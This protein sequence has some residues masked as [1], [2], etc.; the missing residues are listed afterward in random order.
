[1]QIEN[2]FKASFCVRCAHGT[3]MAAVLRER[4]MELL[5]LASQAFRGIRPRRR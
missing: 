4:C 1:M 3:K 2:P 5:A